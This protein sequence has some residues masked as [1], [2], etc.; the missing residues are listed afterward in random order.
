MRQLKRAGAAA[1]HGFA[2]WLCAALIVY[3][4]SA[5]PEY[6]K[7]ATRFSAIA[8]AFWTAFRLYFLV[9]DDPVHPLAAAALALGVVAAIDAVV[10]AP[11]YLHPMDIFK[12]FWDWQ[13]PAAV[14][15]A[16]V[17]AAG[18]RAEPK[19]APVAAQNR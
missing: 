18:R 9:Q 4:A 5:L 6:A 11:Y 15:V 19:P 8:G 2:A 7:E 10:L 13:L 1:G 16:A 14:A 17:W 12:S 3:A